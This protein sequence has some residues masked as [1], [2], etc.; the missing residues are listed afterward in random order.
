MISTINDEYCNLL[1]DKLKQG[2]LIAFL[3]SA[4]S[5]TY[6][7][8]RTNK[9]YLGIKMASEIVKDLSEKK[10]Y[11]KPNMNFEQAFFTVKYK[12]ERNEVERLL[13][14]YINVH[15]INPLPAHS[16][17]SDLGFSAYLTTNFDNLLEKALDSKK[18]YSVIIDD[19]DISRWQMKSKIPIIKLHGC[20]SRPDTMIA[21]EDEYKPLNSREPVLA[22]LIK[23]LLSNK[24][25]LFCG[26]S[27]SDVDFRIAY[28]ELKNILGN[29][30]PKS[31]AVVYDFT[32]YEKNYWERQGVILIKFDLTE[33]LKKLRN[34]YIKNINYDNSSW[35][36]NT[37]F[38]KLSQ[39]KTSPTETQAINAFLE[40]LQQEIKNPKLSIKDIITQAETAIQEIKNN[41]KMFK[42]MKKMW[43]DVQD[44]L[45]SISEEDIEEAE[46]TIDDII[47]QRKSNAELLS[48]K[49]RTIVTKDLNIL[50]YSQSIRVM[51]LLKAVSKRIQ[52]TCTIYICECRPKSVNAFQDAIDICEYLKDT[53][54]TKI[55]IPDATVGNVLSRKKVDIVLMG[56]HA[57]YYYNNNWVSF[58]NTC[59]TNMILGMAKLYSVQVYIVAES[60]KIN[61]IDKIDNDQTED[62]IYNEEE[63]TFNN[64]IP[65]YREEN[66]LGI[67]NTRYDLCE[68]N[69]NIVLLTN[70]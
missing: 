46:Q 45:I 4:V 5:K 64:C 39:S 37:F 28:Q 31:Y 60:S 29:Y 2:D 7:D 27:L 65:E 53:L 54:Y 8:E 49:H 34:T 30:M 16:I 38:D 35:T 66:N 20:I 70:D 41:K 63:N 12:E 57:L 48:K 23:V 10:T 6:K 26:F 61:K 36:N 62:V 68:V 11:I 17:L 44:M 52:Q 13:Q 56:A 50:L 1:S 67:L 58:V 55:I 47:E 69:S 40:Q 51:D 9:T 43:N 18:E 24:V 19:K 59:G 3:G 14:G 15:N 32:E 33:F 42:S 21:C 22:S 25:I